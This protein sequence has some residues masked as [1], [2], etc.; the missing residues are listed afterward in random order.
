MWSQRD[1]ALRRSGVGNVF[2]KGLHP[3]IGHKELHDTFAQFGRILSCKVVTDARNVSKEY[4]FVHY[5]T[6]EA[7][8]TAIQ[9]VNGMLLMDKEVYVGRH[10]PRRARET[11]A[12]E[13]KAKFT[14]VFVK[15]LPDE[16]ASDA[17]LAKLFAPYGETAN[18]SLA[19]HDE[20]GATKGFGFVNFKS[21]DAAVKAVEALNGSEL[22]GKKLYVARAQKKTERQE[23]LRRQ[24]EQAKVE[25]LNKYQGTNLFIKYLEYT[26][27]DDTLKQH[28]EPFGQIHS[29]KVM[30]DANN[31]SRGFG[32]VCYT[33]AEDAARALTEMNRKMISGKPIYVA[34]AQR[35][36]ERKQNQKSL[37]PYPSLVA[38][39]AMMLAPGIGGMYAPQMYFPGNMPVRG[40]PPNYFAPPPGAV[41]GR[42]KWSMAGP[43]P[44]QNGLIRGPNGY[45]MSPGPAYMGAPNHPAYARPIIQQQQPLPQQQQ[46]PRR[47]NAATA[48]RASEEYDQAD[49]HPPSA[50]TR[51]AEQVLDPAV[52]ATWPDNRQRDVLGSQLFA[53]VEER[54]MQGHGDPA[55]TSRITGILLDYASADE[56]GSR[57]SLKIPVVLELLENGHDLGEHMDQA[58]KLL[59]ATAP[60][61][62]GSA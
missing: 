59:S 39:Q 18:A 52:I 33:N 9:S 34:L 50:N 40:A 45:H 28:F 60:G 4:G 26:V 57:G 36:E 38:P 2:I 27:D 53:K 58:I 32:F 20:S 7:A 56:S 23:E 35:K 11:R 43:P 15:E 16:V 46:A 47:R 42:N 6:Q 25:R 48:Q 29:H 44:P 1:P 31:Q 30:R 19:L 49:A 62:D 17:D 55:L 37:P 10:I 14:N 41:H 13:L 21:H 24:Y 54:L 61:Y 51:P 8:N 5:E 3:S 12:E 22:H